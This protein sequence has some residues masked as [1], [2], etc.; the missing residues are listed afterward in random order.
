M[1]DTGDFFLCTCD[2]GYKTF[3]SNQQIF[4]FFFIRTFFTYVYELLSAYVDHGGQ[5]FKWAHPMQFLA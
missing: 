4:V 3:N 1:V 2:L 5:M